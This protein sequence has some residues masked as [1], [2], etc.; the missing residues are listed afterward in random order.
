M[1]L[2]K[3]SHKSLAPVTK[4]PF[5]LEKEIQ[6]LVEENLG[7]LF[8][9]EFV[10]SEFSLGAFRLDTL[11][12]DQQANA[13]VIIEYK[14]GTSY[15]VID[16]GYSYLSLMLN[17]KADFILEYNERMEENLKKD[18]VDWASSKVLFVSPSFNG[19][20]KNSVNFRDV[21]FE[22]WEIKRFEDGLI[23]MEQ[24]QSSSNESIDSLSGSSSNSVISQV[25]AEVSSVSEDE[26]ASKLTPDVRQVWDA[27]REKLAEFP[28]TTFYTTKSYVGWRKGS[29]AIAFINFQKDRICP[30][31]LRGQKSAEGEESKGFFY[32]DDPKVMAVEKLWT[33][34]SG[35]T[36][37]I[38][39]IQLSK[40][41]EL[42]YVLFLLKQ[43][44][45]SM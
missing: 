20:Q 36:G 18:E 27:L 19:Y 32:L 43:K 11:A 38:Y 40:R 8:G 28:D 4:E 3:L 6:D 14:K 9:L 44:Y 41:A 25:S 2:F 24:H 29:K 35:K 21:P 30:E 39:R 13:F 23:A 5:D 37:H 42:E 34:K 15:S 16:Q 10:A 33:W 22:L 45:D 17:N 7:L 31:I 26:L 1:D 12:F